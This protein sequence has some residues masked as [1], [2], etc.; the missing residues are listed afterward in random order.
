[1]QGSMQ[2]CRGGV[3][4]ILVGD[5]PAS[6]DFAEERDAEYGEDAHDEYDDGK[7]IG[8]AGDGTAERDKDLVEALDAL[9][10]AEDAE[11]AHVS[12]LRES[13]LEGA[14]HPKHA[15]R[16]DD[17]VEHIPRRVEELPKPVSVPVRGVRVRVIWV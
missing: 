10:E 9:E 2:G 7:G 5:G 16:H 3:S 17:D 13:A 11:G 1:M 14:T 12:K 15:E 6:A 8:D 4:I